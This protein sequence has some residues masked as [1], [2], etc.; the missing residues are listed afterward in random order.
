M[1]YINFCADIAAWMKWSNLADWVIHGRGC[2][3]VD[4]LYSRLA[5]MQYR[6]STAAQA[7]RENGCPVSGVHRRT[8]RSPGPFAIHLIRGGL[9]AT[10]DA[11]ALPTEPPESIYFDAR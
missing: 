8:T 5:R 1:V 11:R 9:H 4:L 10:Y 3:S 7:S 2:R 6:W